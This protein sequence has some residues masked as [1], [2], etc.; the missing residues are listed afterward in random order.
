MFCID[1]LKRLNTKQKILE[2]FDESINDI[3][4]LYHVKDGGFSYF[5]NKSQTH[6]Y[7]VNITQGNKTADIHGTLLCV[8]GFDDD[9]RCKQQIRF[10]L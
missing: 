10:K 2:I 6:Y 1:A 9:T 7:G 5:K 3:K 4:D 8:L